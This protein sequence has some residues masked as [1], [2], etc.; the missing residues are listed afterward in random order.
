MGNVGVILTLG[1]TVIVFVMAIL[2]S[3]GVEEH[4]TIDNNIN[5]NNVVFL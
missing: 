2:L 5:K 3:V 1:V 4:P